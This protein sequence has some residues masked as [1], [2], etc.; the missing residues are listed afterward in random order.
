[1]RDPKGAQKRQNPQAGKKRGHT[2]HRVAH[3]ENPRRQIPRKTW[4]KRESSLPKT[5]KGGPTKKYTPKKA[6]RGEINKGEGG[7]PAGKLGLGEKKIGG[8]NPIG[9]LATKRGINTFWGAPA[10][11]KTPEEKIRGVYSKTPRFKSKTGAKPKT[12]SVGKNF[13]GEKFPKRAPKGKGPPIP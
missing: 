11:K 4:G 7:C 2:I 10:Q 1:M 9:P 12:A 13:F 8:P 5:T 6:F 3:G